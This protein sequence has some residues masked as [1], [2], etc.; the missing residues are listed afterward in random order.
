MPAKRTTQS[1]LTET[2]ACT[3]L[4]RRLATK[5]AGEGA[6][7]RRVQLPPR[8]WF[9]VSSSS[10]LLQRP[11]LINLCHGLIAVACNA[12]VK[13]ATF[14]P[15]IDSGKS[16]IAAVVL[17]VFHALLVRTSR[18]D[19]GV[20]VYPDGQVRSEICRDSYLNDPDWRPFTISDFVLN[21]PLRVMKV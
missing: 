10:G 14:F 8:N 20:S 4:G 16:V 12:T 17:S 18:H 3:V 19:S 9:A 15:E 2:S 21:S 13:P 1:G 6:G 5:C 7:L 11:S